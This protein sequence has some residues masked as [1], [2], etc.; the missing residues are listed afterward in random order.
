MFQIATNIFEIL[1]IC[2]FKSNTLSSV[3]DDNINSYN[4]D[5]N[6]SCLALKRSKN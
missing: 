5:S 2:L 3:R 1:R 4:S 6:E